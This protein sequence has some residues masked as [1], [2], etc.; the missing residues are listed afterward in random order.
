MLFS[1]LC[2]GS[3][4]ILEITP[5]LLMFVMHRKNFEV[6]NIELEDS[7]NSGTFISMG[8]HP[9]MYSDSNITG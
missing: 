6:N 8:S 5:I 7:E 9:E 2:F 1:A 3:S 4:I